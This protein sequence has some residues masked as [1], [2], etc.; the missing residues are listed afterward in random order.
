MTI[1]H[2]QRIASGHDLNRTAEAFAGVFADAAQG[3]VD[4]EVN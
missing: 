3:W 2:R 4:S 1:A